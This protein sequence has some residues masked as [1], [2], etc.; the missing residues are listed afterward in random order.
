MA[1]TTPAAPSPESGEASELAARPPCVGVLFVHGAGDHGVGAT[2]IEFG[3][4]L[5]AWLDGWLSRAQPSPTSA[6]D[7]AR[8]GATQLLVREA[9]SH[10]PAHATVSMKSRLDQLPHTWLLAEARWDEAFTPPAF[11][12]V[13]KWAIGVVPWTVLTQFLGPLARQSKFVEANPWSVLGFI[14]R[15]FVA[16]ATAL[17]V[18][19]ALQVFALAILVLSIIPIA[20]IRDLV[21]RLQRFASTGVGDLY[22]VL[23]SPIQRAALTSAVQRDVDWMRSQGCE[24]IALVAHSQGGYVAYQALADPWHRAVELFVTFGSGLIRLTE[25]EKARRTGA[26]VPALI[27]TLGALI[28]IRFLP[29]AIL[30]EAGIWEKRQAS[31]LAFTIGALISGILIPVLWRY[32]HDDSRIPD[33]PSKT[34]WIDLLT[35]EDPVM[36]RKRL[37]RLPGRV[38]MIRVQNQGSVVADHG[39]YWLNSDEFVPRVAIR[40]ADLDPGLRLI[41]AGPKDDMRD[42]VRHLRWGRDRRHGRVAALQRRNALLVAATLAV[43]LIRY[44][45]LAAIGRPVGEWFGQLPSFLVSWVPTYVGSVLPIDGIEDLILGGV[46]IIAISAVASRIGSAIWDAWGRADTV[47]QWA[48]R[49][50]AQPGETSLAFYGWTVLHLVV[51]ALVAIVGPGPIVIG[52]DFVARNR[53]PIVQAW[54]REFLWSLGV[55]AIAIVV[56]IRRQGPPFRLWIPA[57]VIGGMVLALAVELRGALL[58]PGPT[59]AIRSIPTGIALGLIG[60][61]VGWAAWPGLR[62]WIAALAAVFERHGPEKS[63]A[64]QP[65]SIVDYLAVIGALIAAVTVPMVVVT[66]S[67]AIASPIRLWQFTA[68]LAMIG[69]FLGATSAL[70]VRGLRMPKVGP[71]T[72]DLVIAP[73][74]ATSMRVVGL[75]GAMVSALTLAAAVVRLATAVGFLS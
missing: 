72:E 31:G 44:D 67:L 54:A 12:Q 19:A 35:K 11:G 58:G 68:L 23:S 28:A 66:P 71:M 41:R 20:S 36:N 18:A 32:F 15:V 25:S 43:V 1:T 29:V 34:P 3:E 53:D 2:L 62:R 46:V 49:E 70:N 47:D 22:M 57:Y 52:L 39:S 50:P 27:G 24:R 51:L 40:I 75:A 21:S 48:G 74:L 16:A 63:V 59:P 60:L 9:D 55:G 17:I 13:L 5:I 7:V 69:L 56:A 33:L 10:A 61:A 42:A 64:D 65:P 45:Q 14:W 37:G 30:G 38:H 73:A 6:T 4:P 8:V 26:L